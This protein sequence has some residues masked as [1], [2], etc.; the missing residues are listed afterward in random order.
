[1]LKIL[2]I[3][4]LIGLMPIAESAFATASNGINDFLRE[5]QAAS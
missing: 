1:M 2:V 4:A 3:L 5:Q